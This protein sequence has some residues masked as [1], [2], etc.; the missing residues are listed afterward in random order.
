MDTERIA[1]CSPPECIREDPVLGTCYKVVL[2]SESK[3]RTFDKV[4][5]DVT[6]LTPEGQGSS[7][8]ASSSGEM[9]AMRALTIQEMIAREKK[10][11]QQE[12]Q[13]LKDLQMKITKAMKPADAILKVLSTIKADLKVEKLPSQ[14][15]V[16]NPLEDSVANVTV[17]YTHLTLPT[18]LLV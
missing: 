3:S 12:K 15:A 10:Q 11:R 18:I 14:M 17:S 6:T 9:M 7:T 13:D 4:L 5:K 16:S 1:R 2:V 8:A